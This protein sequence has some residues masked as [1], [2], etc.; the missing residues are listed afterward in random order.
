MLMMTKVATFV[1]VVMP[2][3]MLL[4]AIAAPAFGRNQYLPRDHEIRE[5][6]RLYSRQRRTL[7][8]AS[9]PISKQEAVTFAER[10]LQ[11]PLSA[12]E[13]EQVEAY[14]ES[15]AYEPE[16]FRYDYEVELS[17]QQ[18]LP[19]GIE[20]DD[21]YHLLRTVKPSSSLR[22]FYGRDDLAAFYLQMDLVKEYAQFDEFEN[23]T[24]FPPF[25]EDNPYAV[26]YNNITRGY[27]Q[28]FFGPLE[29]VFGRQ[30]AHLGPSPQHALHVSQEVPFLDA[31][32][33][34]LPLGRVRMTM[35]ISTLE[36]RRARGERSPD[37]VNVPVAPLIYGYG[38]SII[39]Y[40]VH[41]FELDLDRLRIGFGAHMVLSRENN[42]FRLSDFFPVFSWHNANVT[43]NNLSLVGDFTFAL[44]PGLQ[45]YLQ[46]GFDDINLNPVGIS[47]DSIPT[48]GSVLGGLVVHHGNAAVRRRSQLELGYTHWLWGSFEDDNYLSRAIYR[49]DLVGD[50][51]WIP[52]TSPFGPGRAW[53]KLRTE[54]VTRHEWDYYA[55]GLLRLENVE[56]DLAQN[57]Y[58]A[59]SEPKGADW[60]AVLDLGIGAGYTVLERL[61]LSVEPG[62]RF[63]RGTSP[64]VEVILGA[65]TAVVI[66]GRLN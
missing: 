13:R 9:F 64:R 16:V 52:L 4:L 27:W 28:Q 61:R 22:F 30:P 24:N 60:E 32:R 20:T 3:S 34:N 26:E 51:R 2:V 56:A 63:S 11:L 19:D 14:I 59:D 53:A 15:L 31:L 21:F 8:T 42:M 7:P 40:N 36:N 65:Q 55:R 49:V 38:D 18:F 1:R 6:E 62:V 57:T 12:R 35:L 48:I 33:F 10:L 46:Y 5:L 58:G 37:D 29:M 43:P 17:Y 39:F 50:N 45:T 66:Q 25:I 47:D 54:A 23:Y 41:R 44:A